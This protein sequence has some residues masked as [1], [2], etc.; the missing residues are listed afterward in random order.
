[1][2]IIKKTS[3]VKKRPVSFMDF[4]LMTIALVLSVFV[5]LALVFSLTISL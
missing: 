3:F 4:L 2:K 5:A 1:M